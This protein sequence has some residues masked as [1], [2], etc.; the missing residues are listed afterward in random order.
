MIMS[1]VCAKA[2]RSLLSLREKSILQLL[3]EGHNTKQIADK[4]R[5]LDQDRGNAPSAYHGKLNI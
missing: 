1:S 4:L 5:S 3:A 2:S